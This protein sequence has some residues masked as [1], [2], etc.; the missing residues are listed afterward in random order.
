MLRAIFE[1]SVVGARA[2]VLV[3]LLISVNA[4]ACAT[5]VGLEEEMEVVTLLGMV[6]RKA[7]ADAF[8]LDT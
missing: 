7:A 6:G 1:D 4:V 5:F 8:E 2:E 3:E